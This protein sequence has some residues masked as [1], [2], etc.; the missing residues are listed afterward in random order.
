MS[1]P[2]WIPASEI[3]RWQ[4]WLGYRIPH[5]NHLEHTAA[6]TLVGDRRAIVRVGW[7]ATTAAPAQW[8]ATLF[9]LTAETPSP[10]ETMRAVQPVKPLGV[11][12]HHEVTSEIPPEA[13]TPPDPRAAAVV[14]L[15]GA[16]RTSAEKARALE[17]DPR[18]PREAVARVTRQERMHRERAL[19]AVEAAIHD[20]LTLREGM[21]LVPPMV[22]KPE[23]LRDQAVY[24]LLRRLRATL[25]SAPNALEWRPSGVAVCEGCTTVFVPRRRATAAY[26]PN[27]SK[28][29][30]A[31]VFG[32]RPLRVG[33]P[34]TIRVP[35]LAG[36]MIVGWKTATIAICPACAEPFVGRVDA[37]MCQR[38]ANRER[39]RR[40]RERRR[41][42]ASEQQAVGRSDVLGAGEDGRLPLE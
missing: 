1:L 42:S 28:R 37:T 41:Q 38:C 8:H 9:T 19:G 32:T 13:E 31:Q 3:G 6:A 18:R 17:R 11:V 20:G 34:Q 23:A 12:L 27:C 33:E 2:K 36:T 26:C 25:D 30:A 16:A 24:A 40:H 39:Q 5:W 14:A 4:A 15:V 7:D 10:D 21:L 29:P 35:E 22:V